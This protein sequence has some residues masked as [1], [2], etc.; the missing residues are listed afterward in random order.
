M[1]VLV[2]DDERIWWIGRVALY[3][4]AALVNGSL[5]DARAYQKMLT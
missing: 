3:L 1:L 4:V 2:S 5:E